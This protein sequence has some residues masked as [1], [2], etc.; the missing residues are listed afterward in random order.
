[1]TGF[2]TADVTI[3]E[4]SLAVAVA[5]TT[6]QRR[7][8][9]QGVDDLPRGVDG[10]LFVF[11]T[12]R[13]A[14]FHMR[15][16]TFDLDIWWF[17]AQGVLVGSTGMTTCLDGQCVSYRSPGEIMWALETPAGEWD[18]SPGSELRIDR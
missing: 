6:S 16:V 13:T 7:Q 11:E 18:F 3:G 5:E 4:E 1:M 9:L 17:D 15:T 12:P 2:G 8:G 14:S 10:M